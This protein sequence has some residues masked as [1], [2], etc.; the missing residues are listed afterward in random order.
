[1]RKGKGKGQHQVWIL[2]EGR[3]QNM[4]LDALIIGGGIAGLQGAIQLGRYGYRVL[5]VDANEGRSSMCRSYHNILGWPDGI[6]GPELRELGRMQAERLGVR[7][8]RGWASDAQSIPGGF[9]VKVEG[10]ELEA[11]T[12]LL[13]TGVKDRFPELP[14]LRGCLG[15][16]IYVCPDCDAY[17][18]RG[19]STLV[20]GSGEV[21]ARMTL[22]LSRWTNRLVYLNHEQ[23]PVSENLLGEL[24]RRG[25]S[26]LPEQAERVL[27]EPGSSGLFQGLILRGGRVIEAERGFIAF[28]GNDVR[29]D[30]AA[31][32]GAT[33]H[34]NRHVEVDPRTKETSVKGL[35][36]AGD[37]GVHAEQVTVAMGEGA[38]AAIWMHKALTKMEEEGS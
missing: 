25:I 4:K 5:V 33:L 26:H 15:I 7:F 38:I 34:Q 2:E 21:G 9:R 16:T 32:L 23:K 11:K 35:W 24:E 13:A 31:K 14:G 36:A 27:L 10:Q 17:E 6:G 18:I 29:S 1:M 3:E 30:L 20:L 8:L 22:T 19:R 28:G 12:M 37:I